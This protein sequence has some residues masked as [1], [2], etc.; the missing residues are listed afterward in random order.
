MG[1]AEAAECESIVYGTVIILFDTVNA[2]VVI[3][4]VFGVN[5]LYCVT[6]EGDVSVV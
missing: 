5:F 1:Y 3:K 6:A 2:A 4:A